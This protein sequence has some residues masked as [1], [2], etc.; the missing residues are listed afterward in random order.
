MSYVMVWVVWTTISLSTALEMFTKE[1][2]SGSNIFSILTIPI[3][4]LR[5]DSQHFWLWTVWSSCFIF[6]LALDRGMVHIHLTIIDE[7]SNQWMF[8]FLHK[9]QGPELGGVLNIA[10][11]CMSIPLPLEYYW[12]KGLL[13]VASTSQPQH[14]SEIHFTVFS[15]FFSTIN[16]LL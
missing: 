13:S 2:L 11:H 8:A 4:W 5:L 1:G 14:W 6:I 10:Y 7:G 3:R 9:N 16:S 12:S 15:F